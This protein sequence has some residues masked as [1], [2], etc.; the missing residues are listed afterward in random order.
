MRYF[1]S[2][3]SN[4]G[5][6]RRNLARAVEAL[7]QAGVAVLKTSSLY[8]TE[9]VGDKE[10]PWFFNLVA[11]VSA[12]LDPE[13][14]LALIQTI[15]RKLG[16]KPGKRGGPRLIDIDILLAEDQIIKSEQ[17][18]IPHPRLHQRNFV[19]QPL[20]E[21]SAEAVHPL[22]GMKIR[23]LRILSADL[24]IVKKLR[25]SLEYGRFARKNQ[26][27]RCL[28]GHKVGRPINLEEET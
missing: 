14:M 6:R 16:R 22:L 4:L 3:G 20:E 21:I 26:G 8:Q 19:L 17:L 18:H 23:D 5:W 28:N 11:E 12:S 1:L 25:H 15:E 13:G 2:L 10:Q 27:K 24:S 7:E 9:P